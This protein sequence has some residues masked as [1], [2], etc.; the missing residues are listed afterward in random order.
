[1]DNILKIKNVNQLNQLFGIYDKHPLISVVD[2]SKIKDH[3]KIDAKVY[4][5]VYAIMLKEQCSGTIKYGRQ[6]IDFQEGTLVFIAPN[7]TVAIQEEI[8]PSKEKDWGI[9]FHPDFLINTS[10]ASRIKDYSFFSYD[11]NEA[12]HLSQKEKS[13]LNDLVQKIEIE[14]SGNIDKHSQM[15]IASNIELLLNYCV[16][17]FDRQ[18]ITRSPK[19][20]DLLSRFEAILSD[21]IH[22]EKIIKQGLPS[23]QYMA[24][25][26]NLS[27]NYLSDLMKRETGKSTIE[28]I[29]YAV[30]EEAKL[31]LASSKES[32]SEIAYDLGFEYPQ[33]FTR[34]FKKISGIAPVEYRN[35]N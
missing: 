22:S 6:L 29:H 15:L 13:I 25:N 10:L 7:Q 14:L 27:A 34:L 31:R 20:Q 2:F 18:F 32:I 35:I 1:M 3:I 30:I 8:V 24:D 28:H 33:Y 23:V 17:Y 4:S 26:L 19:H 12:L 9:F 21:Y 16:R 11:T 5:E